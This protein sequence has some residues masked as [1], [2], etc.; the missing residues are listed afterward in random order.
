[1]PTY[2]TT[3]ANLYI[4][5]KSDPPW[6]WLCHKHKRA[7]GYSFVAG[8]AFLANPPYLFCKDVNA[9]MCPLYEETEHPETPDDRPE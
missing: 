7:P 1:M 2:C 3:C 6:R 9:G 5:N 8:E 4:V